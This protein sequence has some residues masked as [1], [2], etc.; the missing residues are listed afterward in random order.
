[1][2]GNILRDARNRPILHSGANADVFFFPPTGR[3]AQGIFFKMRSWNMNAAR[4]SSSIT[5]WQKDPA[6]QLAQL[7][8]FADAASLEQIGDTASVR[9]IGSRLLSTKTTTLE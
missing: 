3:N 9:P 1:V 8:R 2:D 6:G 4:I 5:S 7:A